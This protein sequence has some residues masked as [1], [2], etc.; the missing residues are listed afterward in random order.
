MESRPVASN[1]LRIA[2]A[3]LYALVPRNWVF[4]MRMPRTL[5]TTHE[6]WYRQNLITGVAMVLVGVEWMIVV[7]VRAE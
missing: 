3:I 2:I 4:G 1:R 5:R 7:A 6:T